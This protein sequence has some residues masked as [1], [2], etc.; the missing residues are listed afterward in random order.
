VLSGPVV[1]VDVQELADAGAPDSRSWLVRARYAGRRHTL[2][3]GGDDGLPLAH[4][5]QVGERAPA[6][7]ER[8]AYR[9]VFAERAPELLAARRGAAAFPPA[10][11]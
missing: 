2:L 11:D 5:G 10:S 8:A 6:P 9:L 3:I 4:N 1:I 7:V